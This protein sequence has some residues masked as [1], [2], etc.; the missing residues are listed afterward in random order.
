MTRLSL[1]FLLAAACGGSSKPANLAPLPDDT[2]QATPPPAPAPEPAPAPPPPPP[3]VEVKLPAPQTTVK[4]VSGG[5][6]KKEVLHY[7]PKVGA[8]QTLEVAMDFTGKQ[9][10]EE[11]VVPTIVLAAEA[12][13]K[14]V[15]NDGAVEY[16]VKVTGTDAREVPGAA[17]PLAQFKPVLGTLTGL[18]YGGKRDANGLTGEVTMRIENPQKNAAEALELIRLTLPQVPVL[19]KEALGV[20][21]KWQATTLAK[22]ADQIDVT[23]VTDYEVTAHKGTS[24]TIKGKTKVS[25]KEQTIENGKITGITGTGT[26]ETTID[27]GALFPA[28]KSQLETTFKAS[29]QDKSLQFSLKVGGALTPKT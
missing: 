5:R 16:S 19:P 1:L 26:S 4:L 13:A 22:L 7:T 15:D 25:G 10:A 8:K 12:E 17:V 21:A 28:H 2:K 11:R 3:P 29:A 6:G 18:T 14:T 20:G 24:W 9:D 23:Q 27:D